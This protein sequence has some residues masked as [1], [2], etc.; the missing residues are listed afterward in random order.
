MSYIVRHHLNTLIQAFLACQESQPALSKNIS[1]KIVSGFHRCD[2]NR[3]TPTID[4]SEIAARIGDGDGRAGRAQVLD[5]KKGAGV[6]SL[7]HRPAL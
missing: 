4:R 2:F 3:K 1:A 6:V 7:R 5:T